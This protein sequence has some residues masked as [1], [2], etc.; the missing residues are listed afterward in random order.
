MSAN[1]N[2]WKVF[3]FLIIISAFIFLLIPAQ[4]WAQEDSEGT[5]TKETAIKIEDELS[6]EVIFNEILGY[7]IIGNSF[8]F[9]VDLVFDSEKEEYFEFEY[10][11]PDGWYIEIKPQSLEQNITSVKL[12]PGKPNSLKVIVR[13]EVPQE[14]GEYE[15]KFTV[16]STE[17]NSDLSSTVIL[18]S[19]V[20]P[21][22]DLKF[23]TEDGRLNTEVIKGKDNSFVLILNNTGSGLVE[24]VNLSVTDAPVR[25]LIDF[26]E[27]II[28]RIEAGDSA[29]VKIKIIPSE[30]AIAG[31]YIIRILAQSEKS[32]T[33]SDIR[34][35]IKVSVNWQ[36]AGIALIVIVVAGIA[37]M[38]Y[39]IGRR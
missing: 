19:I 32:T 27:D 12:K 2:K 33:F 38:F 39:R 7:G 18:K 4:I 21:S 30:K 36:V 31:D 3:I 22:G 9:K 6:A 37:L 16:K 11:L 10:E 24:N 13:P 1:I 25:W 29:N 23:T 8:E 26:E 28:K 35:T 15:T 5:T 14:P 34:T 20:K 17:E